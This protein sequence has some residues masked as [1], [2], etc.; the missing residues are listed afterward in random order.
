MGRRSAVRASRWVGNYAYTERAPEHASSA[1]QS[2]QSFPIRWETFQDDLHK[3]HGFVDF[4]IVDD[5]TSYNLWDDLLEKGIVRLGVRPE[6]YS[7]GVGS[8]ARDLPEGKW[9]ML[10]AMRPLAADELY[11]RAGVAKPCATKLP[12]IYCLVHGQAMGSC[13]FNV[14]LDT[15]VDFMQSKLG[16]FIPSN[17]DTV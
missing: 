2:E 13:V 15:A 4:L 16:V 17:D 12:A 14:H 5:Y 11:A 1:K 3:E 7:T 6:G 8:G 9:R 10:H